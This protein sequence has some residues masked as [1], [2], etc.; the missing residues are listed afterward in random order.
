M[1]ILKRWALF[2]AFLMLVGRGASAQ[3]QFY[4]KNL[5]NIKVEQLSDDQVLRFRQQIESGKMTEKDLIRYFTGKGLSPQEISKLKARMGGPVGAN[6]VGSENQADLYESDIARQYYNLL[7]SLRML[8]EEEIPG[9]KFSHRKILADSVVFGSEL[10]SRAKL[11]FSPDLKL[12][13]PSGYVLGPGDELN[14]VIY[15]AHE[16]SFDLIVSP[17]GRI[18]IPYGGMIVVGGLTVDQAVKKIGQIL[19]KSGI[20]SLGSGQSQLVISIQEFRSIPVTVVGARVPGTYLLPAIA[21]VFHALYAAGGP[22]MN[23]TYREIE[24][25]RKGKVIKK[26]DLY[27]FLVNGDDTDFINIRE[28][29]VINIPVYSNRIMLKGEVKRPGL[30]ELKEKESFSQLMRFAGG[31]SELAFKERVQIVEI[32]NG[33]MKAKSLNVDDFSNYIPTTGSIVDVAAVVNVIRSQVVASGA[34]MRPGKYA[35]AEGMKLSDLFSQAKGVEKS[36]LLNRGLVY[37]KASASES[38]YLRFNV[39]SVLDGKS[40]MVLEDGDSVVVIDRV[41]MQPEAEVLVLGKVQA[42]GPVL[43][44]KGM[45]AKDAILLAGG[46]TEDAFKSQVEISRRNVQKGGDISSSIFIELSDS[47]LSIGNDERVLQPGDVVIVREDDAFKSQRMVYLNGEVLRPGPY[48]LNSK[49]EKLSAL[50]SRAGGLTT[51]ANPASCFIVRKTTNPFYGKTLLE[52]Q[53]QEARF[54]LESNSPAGGA[55]G[56]TSKPTTAS[57]AT[58][59]SEEFEA[60]NQELI[61]GSMMSDSVF[62]DTIS[63]DLSEILNRRNSSKFD[64]IL[65]EGDMITVME[66]RSTVSVRGEVNSTVIV[67][68]HSRRLKSYVKDAGGFSKNADKKRIFVI[69]PNGRSRMTSSFMGIRVYPKIQPGVEVIVPSKIY[70][71]RKTD[72]A[73]LAAVA[74]VIA[75]TTSVLF[76][77]VTLAR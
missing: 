59:T 57:N 66:Y 56:F 43:Y 65:K 72:P 29:D 26:I 24:I 6:K 12:A 28:N 74:S 52:K 31:F 9:D 27:K 71:E 39:T 33:E 34:F 16:G 35:W 8:E 77:I 73:K 37:R 21:N 45:T 70:D 60:L 14:I 50:V 22:A 38:A 64:L 23:G 2:T 54:V 44:A 19:Q 13:A 76:L 63:I 20:S 53:S 47:L 58:L 36:A 42:E 3:E 67:N 55:N 48:V 49:G 75:S 1:E 15:G 25:I 18:N 10:F 5:A 68:H 61:S 17:E 51:Y 46:F 32:V 7:D 4:K 11:G 69:E 62:L 41:M 40:D 30:F